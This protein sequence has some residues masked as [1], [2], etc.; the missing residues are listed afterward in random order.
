MTGWEN[1]KIEIALSIVLS[2]VC[3]L[4]GRGISI[5]I[6]SPATLLMCERLVDVKSADSVCVHRLLSI[7]TVAGKTEVHTSMRWI[8]NGPPTY[9]IILYMLL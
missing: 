9:V 3:Y 4:S 6:R 2:N 7:D 5:F 1:R 8:H